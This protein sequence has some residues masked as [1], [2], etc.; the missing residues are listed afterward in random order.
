MQYYK[1]LVISV[2]LLS[3]MPFASAAEIYRWVDAEGNTQFSNVPPPNVDAQATGRSTRMPAS[4][5]QAPTTGRTDPASRAASQP[6]KSATSTQPNSGT[7][8]QK[9]IDQVNQQKAEHARQEAGRTAKPNAGQ[10]WRQ[11]V[12]DKCKANRGINCTDPHYVSSKRP[13]S[14]SEREDIRRAQAERREREAQ[15]RSDNYCRFNR[16]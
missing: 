15:Q 10:N 8:I 13:L 6:Q 16:C 9:L 7:N 3:G 14:D 4:A 5:E 12:I 11:E 1:I 2:F